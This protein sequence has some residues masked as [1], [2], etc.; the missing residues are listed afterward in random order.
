MTTTSTLTMTALRSVEL[1][2]VLPVMVLSE[3]YLYPGCYLPLFIFEERY[4]LMLEHALLTDRMFCIGTRQE[5]SGK[6]LPVSVA[7]LI[8]SCIKQ[9]DGTSRLV[10]MG[11]QRIH[12]RNWV[13]GGPFEMIEIE[14]L[15]TEPVADATLQ[16]LRQE[17]MGLLPSFPPDISEPLKALINTLH[18]CE[19]PELLCDLITYHFIRG[20]EA[21]SRILTHSCVVNRYA[22]L[23]A[24][25]RDMN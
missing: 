9:A 1:P 21:Q 3:C 8:H 22:T 25:L 24:E 17:A 10:L 12:L 6:I 11:L 4:R 13:H 5:S 15:L 2:T 23:L 19:D 16:T 20:D 18:A 14:P 7:G